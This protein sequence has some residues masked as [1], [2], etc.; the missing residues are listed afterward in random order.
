MEWF[1]P[2]RVGLINGW[3]Y[4]VVF[5]LGYLLVLASFPKEIV[6]RLYDRSG[7]TKQQRS[8]SAAGLPFA[9]AGLI[10]IVFTPLKIGTPV[11]ILGTVGYVLGF[12][13]FVIALNQFKKAPLDEPALDG[14]YRISRHPQWVT[15]VLT[16]LGVSIA[17]GSWTIFLLL[18][19][20]VVFNH[21]RILGEE[22]ACL[23]RYGETYR[24]Y[25]EHVPRYF[26]CF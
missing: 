7:W 12:I 9:I 20:R 1:P 18:G 5:Y 19:V 10:L 2:L 3:I 11:F 26:L 4:L 14:L 16:L 8:Y 15:F 24:Q 13:G 22:R 17:L 25:L 23:E 21:F 6:Q